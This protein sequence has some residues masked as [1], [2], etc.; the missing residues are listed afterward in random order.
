MKPEAKENITM[1]AITSIVSLIGIIFLYI[2]L[3]F[4]PIYV[5]DGLSF[6]CWLVTF[7]FCDAIAIVG[8]TMLGQ[9]IQDIRKEHIP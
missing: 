3:I 7:L 4:Y 2:T 5:T 1:I 8:V 6:L 9:V